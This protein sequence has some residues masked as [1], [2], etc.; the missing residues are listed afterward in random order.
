VLALAIH[1][2]LVVTELDSVVQFCV[3]VLR[4][5]VSILRFGEGVRSHEEHA[6]KVIRTAGTFVNQYAI[7]LAHATGQ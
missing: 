7:D 2:E 6:T 5:S 1:V 3:G 4:S